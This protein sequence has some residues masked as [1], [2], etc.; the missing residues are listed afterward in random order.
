MHTVMYAYTYIYIYMQYKAQ[1]I[2]N[3]IRMNNYPKTQTQTRVN[4]LQ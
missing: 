1:A 3:F 2:Q 4:K